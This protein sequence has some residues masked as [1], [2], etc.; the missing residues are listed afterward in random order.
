MAFPACVANHRNTQ[1][2]QPRRRDDGNTSTGVPIREQ[3][4]NEKL[5][6]THATHPTVP[7]FT[8]ARCSGGSRTKQEHWKSAD[9]CHGL[10]KFN[11]DFPV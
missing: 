7:R 2:Q 5:Q 6:I 1:A 10:S 9:L 3:A 8:W 11:A 4:V